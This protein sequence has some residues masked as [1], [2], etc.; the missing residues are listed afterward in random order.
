M[1]PKK[2]NQKFNLEKF[3]IAKL[4]NAKSVAGGFGEPMSSQICTTDAANISSRKCTFPAPKP[5]DI[6]FT[7]TP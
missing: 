2:Q 7:V 6:G 5:G 3:E 1:K 4:T